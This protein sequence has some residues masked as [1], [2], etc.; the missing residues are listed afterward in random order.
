MIR[1]A[2]MMAG[3]TGAWLLARR[4]PRG[5]AFFDDSAEGVYHSFWAYALLYPGVILLHA[6]NGV[7]SGEA[8]V[9]YP[10]LVKTASFV[11]GAAAFPLVMATVADGFERAPLYPRFIVAYNWSSVVQ[12]AVFLPAGLVSALMPVHGTA[13]LALSVT[14]VLLVYQA[15]VTHVVLQIKP[16]QA[17]AVVLLD[18]LLTAV[19]QG[20]AERLL[21][22]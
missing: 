17:A 15:Y 16:A 20:W 14:L 11:F 22:G 10:L 6:V 4:D 7:F 18:V 1:A 21:E 2:E 3:L 12:L 13:M 5:I 8:G 9:L 19:I